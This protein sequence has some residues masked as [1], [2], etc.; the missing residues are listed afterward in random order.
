ME[1]ELWVCCHRAI[2]PDS[3]VASG[4]WE[5]GERGRLRE[6]SILKYRVHY[7][8]KPSSSHLEL[9]LPSNEHARTALKQA[10]PWTGRYL[11]MISMSTLV[12]HLPH[13]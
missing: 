11:G 6:L 1:S 8:L 3:R 12:F 9:C 10:E 4:P 2:L 13:C 7:L 5:T